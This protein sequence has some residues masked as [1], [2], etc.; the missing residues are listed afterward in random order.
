MFT[1][2]NQAFSKQIIDL[3]NRFMENQPKKRKTSMD[4]D[5]SSK[6]GTSTQSQDE[7]E[8]VYDDNIYSNNRE[9]Q[10]LYE[11][12]EEEEDDQTAEAYLTQS[13]Y[14]A[15]PRQTKPEDIIE[16]VQIFQKAEVPEYYSSI[17]KTGPPKTKYGKFTLQISN[18]IISLIKGIEESSIIPAKFDVDCNDSFFNDLLAHVNAK[19]SASNIP[20]DCFRIPTTARSSLQIA[21]KSLARAQQTLKILIM[22]AEAVKDQ[23]ETEDDQ[24]A[25]DLV[26]LYILPIQNQ[27]ESVHE[28][29][30]RIRAIS[31]PK[32]I[33]PF[34]KKVVIA[35][36]INPGNIWSISNQTQAK[37]NS[38]RV[39]FSRKLQF[40]RAPPNTFNQPRE[41][42][43]F[44]SR[45][46]FQDRRARPQ[47]RGGHFRHRHEQKQE[48]SR[49]NSEK[50]Q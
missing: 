30:R 3:E 11:N 27:I 23:F 25:H 35:A 16:A 22:H 19:Y 2:M 40:K 5:Y 42:R 17:A 36:P 49:N 12:E 43:P 32:Y 6:P 20:E 14:Q 13:I 8:I 10:E 1:K 26:R 7:E 38:A 47:G 33:P 18:K 39:E 29:I 34:L 31:L 4:H 50:Q 45:G 15:K 41:S 46:R 21:Y 48:S 24:K 9:E 37:I 44:Q 28:Q